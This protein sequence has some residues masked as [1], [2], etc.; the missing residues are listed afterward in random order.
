V[1]LLIAV[2]AY[3]HILAAVGWLGGNVFFGF[4]VAPALRL[5]NPSVAA[6]FFAKVGSRPRRF[7]TATSTL[8][9]VFGVLL[10]YEILGGDFGALSFS[11]SFG[12]FI[13][14]GVAFAVV[15]YLEGILVTS[16]KAAKLEK[17]AIQAQASGQQG[18]GPEAP[19][20]LRGLGLGSAIGVILLLLVLV[21]MVSA[22]F[23]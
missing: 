22:G 13:M 15:A 20:V 6:E 17:M 12:M 23:Y 1:S 7:F 19:S 16:P 11:N 21:F 14:L 4:A 3:V 2:L 5:M 8:T 18:L 9:V 10:L